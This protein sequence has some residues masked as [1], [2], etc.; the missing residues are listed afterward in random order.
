MTTEIPGE[1]WLE[2]TWPR[3]VQSARNYVVRTMRWW[4]VRQLKLACWATPTGHVIKVKADAK[5][6][7]KF[8]DWQAQTGRSYGSVRIFLVESDD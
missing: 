1:Q 6:H 4:G 5:H 7:Q 2:K 8:R 3:N